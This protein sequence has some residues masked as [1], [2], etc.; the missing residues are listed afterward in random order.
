MMNTAEDFCNEEHIY[1]T[2]LHIYFSVSYYLHI[3]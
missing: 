3:Y 1:F 2:F